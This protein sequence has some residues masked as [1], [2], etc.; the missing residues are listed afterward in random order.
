MVRPALLLVAAV[1]L[2]VTGPTVTGP[3]VTAALADEPTTKVAR[4]S[5]LN[6]AEVRE[7]VARHNVARREVG[8]PPVAWS[9]ALGEFAQAWADEIARTGKFEHRPSDRTA[10]VFYGENLAAGFGP[11]YGVAAALEQWRREEADYVTGTPVPELP[12]DFA[13]FKAGHYTQMV[14]R[15]TRSI[16]VGKAVIQTGDMA[17]WTVFVANYDPPGNAGGQKPY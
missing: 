16:G 9:P 6:A 1:G 7:V 12:E 10:T 11:G 8:V 4:P 17:G 5:R 14:W 13:Q 2:S 3:T 15:T